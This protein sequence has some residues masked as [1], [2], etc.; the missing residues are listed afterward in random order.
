MEELAENTENILKETASKFVF[1]PAALDESTDVTD[2]TQFLK[3]C[4]NTYICTKRVA[5][6][7]IKQYGKG[8]PVII[9]RPSII[10]GSSKEPVPG[11]IDNLYGTTGVGVGYSTGFKRIMECDPNVTANIIPADVVA[12]II[13]ASVWNL[14]CRTK[15]DSIKDPPTNKGTQN[16]M[17]WDN[18]C[19]LGKRLWSISIFAYTIPILILVKDKFKFSIFKFFLHYLPALLIDIISQRK[20]A[21]KNISDC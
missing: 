6:S 8:L 14:N 3:D 7:L 11:W 9:V 5:E 18:F 4:P 2:T 13:I 1:Y 17:T 20:K 19:Q 15:K 12:N 21:A 10:T 16:P